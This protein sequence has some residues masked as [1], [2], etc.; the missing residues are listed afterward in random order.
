M[1]QPDT[2]GFFLMHTYMSRFSAVAFVAVFSVLM[3]SGVAR[4]SHDSTP[5]PYIVGSTINLQSNFC[6]SKVA[7]EAVRK[8]IVTD[9][10]TAK[11]VHDE[12]NCSTEADFPLDV[13]VGNPIGD[14]FTSSGGEVWNIIEATRIS[15]SAFVYVLSNREIMTQA[16]YDVSQAYVIGQVYDF[17]MRYICTTLEEAEEVLAVVAQTVENASVWD[18]F[19][20]TISENC[21]G[22]V[23][24]VTIVEQIGEA[25]TDG[26]Q[27][28]WTLVRVS[29][30]E[31]GDDVY[32]FNVDRPTLTRAEADA[33]LAA[34]SQTMPSE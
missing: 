19:R 34:D 27:R 33:M 24:M 14:P 15:D 20:N 9:S 7:A 25:V 12:N 26:K 10:S 22:D 17:S 21:T 3:V 31:G 5:K 1:Q 30:D 11:S 8:A 4:A 28:M 2:K 32:L 29:P 16:E 23:S 6:E 18:T 13:I